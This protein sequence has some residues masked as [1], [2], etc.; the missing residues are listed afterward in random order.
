MEGPVNLNA[1]LEVK[2]DVEVK[3]DLTE[4]VTALAQSGGR[5]VDAFANLVNQLPTGV[6]AVA[7]IVRDW[8]G[9]RSS[10]ALAV[11]EGATPLLNEDAQAPDD[12]WVDEL[13]DLAGKRSKQDFQRMLS[14]LFALECNT[15]DSVPLRYINFMAALD[16]DVLE[17]FAYYLGWY[18]LSW[19]RIIKGDPAASVP[20]PQYVVQANLIIHHAMGYQITLSNDQPI[21]Y[22]IS[23]GDQHYR[24][25]F[26]PRADVPLGC[27]QLTSFGEMVLELLDPR[28]PSRSEALTDKAK[29]W[30]AFKTEATE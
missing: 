6:R 17:E 7:D 25:S 28:P 4:G 9:R 18:D 8:R 2:A 21:A 27:Y 1:N 29:L 14:R 22:V 15:I 24:F 12:D 13:L 30:E 20:I 26:P 3:A 5:F 23:H 19:G 11:L 16:K 10:N